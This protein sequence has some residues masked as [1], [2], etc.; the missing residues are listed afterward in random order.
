MDQFDLIKGVFEPEEAKEILLY[1]ID[2]KIQFH[3][4]RIFSDK[5]RFGTENKAS[6]ARIAELENT[7]EQILKLIAED[8]LLI[9]SQINIEKIAKQEVA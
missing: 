6:V 4:N 2:G 5:I 9:H 3:Q 8:N 7:R 1:L